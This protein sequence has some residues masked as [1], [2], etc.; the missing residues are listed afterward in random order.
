[1][2]AIYSAQN[3]YS[4]F[5]RI[6]YQHLINIA[7]SISYS[8]YC[9]QHYHMGTDLERLGL[10]SHCLGKYIWECYFP[11]VHIDRFDSPSF[12]TVQH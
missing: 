7:G 12:Q 11:Q 6:Y 3:R 8:H 10:Q 5:G 2:S 9:S 4:I 1:M